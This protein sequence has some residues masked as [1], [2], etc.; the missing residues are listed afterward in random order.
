[1][2]IYKAFDTVKQ[3]FLFDLLELFGFG[4][5]FKKAI[6]ALY[7]EC[8]S[9]IELPWGTTHRFNISLGIKQGDPVAPFLFLLVMQALALLIHNDSFQCISIR[10][11]GIKCCQLADDTAIF[12][13]IYYKS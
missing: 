13:K 12:K 8:N 1:M 9:S 2:C 11:R 10:D 7:T 5:Y 3:T 6:Q 4:Q